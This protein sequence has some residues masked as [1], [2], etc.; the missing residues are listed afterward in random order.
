[1]SKFIANHLDWVLIAGILDKI[2][3]FL[4]GDIT[5]SGGFQNPDK[6]KRS[7]DGSI[8]RSEQRQYSGIIRSV[9]AG[10]AL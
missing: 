8:E 3:L 5:L 7:I 2:D 10:Y 9:L 6:E 4:R 1:M